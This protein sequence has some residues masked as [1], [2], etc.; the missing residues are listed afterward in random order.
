MK[1]ATLAYFCL[2][3]M[4]ELLRREGADLDKPFERYLKAYSDC[5]AVRP[6]GLH[7]GLAICRGGQ[8]D[9]L[10]VPT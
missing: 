10:V 6:E 5:I 3:K 8:T 9:C 1:D 2:D 4:R 7:V